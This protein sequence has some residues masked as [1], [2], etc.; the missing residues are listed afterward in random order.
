MADKSRPI[1][2][3]RRRAGLTWAEA[4]ADPSRLGGDYTAA[5][6]ERT[7]RLLR[8]CLSLDQVGE[9]VDIVDPDEAVT[10]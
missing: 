8:P 5:Q 3:V 6:L 1:D 7:R 9:E 2:A 4:I 10:A